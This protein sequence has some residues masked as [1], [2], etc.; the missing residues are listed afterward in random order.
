MV[1]KDIA[2]NLSSYH[3]FKCREYKHN[4]IWQVSRAFSTYMTETIRIEQQLPTSHFPC[5][6]NHYSMFYFDAFHSYMCHVSGIMQ[7]FVLLWLAFLTSITSSRFVHVVVHDRF[8][9]LF[10]DYVIF[11]VCVYTTFNSFIIIKLVCFHLLGAVINAVMNMGL[12]TYLWD[13]VFSSFG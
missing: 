3:I 7:S 10:Y 6:S 8:S 12:Q 13:P 5:P 2:W 4:V 9:F 1:K 11:C